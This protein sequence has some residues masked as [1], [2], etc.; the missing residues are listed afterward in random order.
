MIEFIRA[1]HIN[2]CVPPERL[3][4]A[5]RFYADVIGLPEMY[6]PDVFGAPGYWFKVAD[7]E[8]HIGIEPAKAPS[9]RHM[10][11]EV[12]NLEEAQKLLEK[13]NVQVLQEA[14]IPGRTRF[15]FI[16]PFGNRT[17]LLQM[18]DR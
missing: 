4:E 11:F 13:N 15:T 6:R 17:E 16:D 18:I 12:R 2:I 10:A 5:R 9:I 7:I 3:E 14:V 8:L 1:D